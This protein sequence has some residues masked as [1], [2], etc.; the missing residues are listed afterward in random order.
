MKTV[1]DIARRLVWWKS[2]GETLVDTEQLL[3]RVM[4]YGALSDVQLMLVKYGRPAF[5]AA[6]KHASPGIFDS[7]SWQYWRLVLGLFDAPKPARNPEMMR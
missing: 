2:P 6:L 7:R 4:A 1:E 3:A 5:I